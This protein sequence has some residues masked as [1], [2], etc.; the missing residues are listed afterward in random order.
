MDNIISYIYLEP[1]LYLQFIQEK[2]VFLD[3]FLSSR[4]QFQKNLEMLS[5]SDFKINMASKASIYMH[6]KQVIENEN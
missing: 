1:Q 6:N 3:K 4:Y 2:Y 5:A